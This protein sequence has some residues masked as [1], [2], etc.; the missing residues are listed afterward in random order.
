M[1]IEARQLDSEIT[2]E[3]DEEEI[4]VHDFAKAF[5]N[6]SGLVREL[7]KQF[8]PQ[9]D[10]SAWLVKVYPG[11]AGIGLSGKPGV[12]TSNEINS[13]RTNLL[14]GLQQL[15]TGARPLYFTDK[16]VECSKA[17]GSLFRS[18][19]APPSV[20]IWSK[21]EQALS[22]GRN[23]AVKAEG[24]LEV[25]YEDDGSVDGFLQKLSAHGQYE[26]VIYDALD[27]RAIKCE[28]EE[29]KLESAWKSFRKRVEVLGKVRYRRDGMPVSVRANNIIPFPSKED[30]PSVP[31]MRRL[32]A[33]G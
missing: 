15:E 9:K 17:L 13:I 16:S 18:K 20:R 11:S 1:A 30:V 19:K 12:Y 26:F 2:L 22:I 21:Q 6:F 25:A 10:S 8:A 4:S 27:D 28:I 5:D 32:L 29:N 33:G 23:I 14:K 31:E 3:L 24:L 7:A